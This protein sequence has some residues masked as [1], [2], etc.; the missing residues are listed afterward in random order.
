MPNLS[1]ISCPATVQCFDNGSPSLSVKK[2]LS[3]AILDSND[4]PTSVLINGSDVTK[5]KENSP[6]EAVVGRLSCL[7]QDA[8]QSHVYTLQSNGD[9]FM[10]RNNIDNS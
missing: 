3:I 2:V 10:V 7:D 4:A 1:I 9:V 6:V 5:L 8:S